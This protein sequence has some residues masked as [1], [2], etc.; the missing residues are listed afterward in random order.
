M[1]CDTDC[2]AELAR[3]QTC[4]S[5]CPVLENWI[6]MKEHISKHTMAFG[7]KM[8]LS[9]NIDSLPSELKDLSPQ[10]AFLIH[11]LIFNLVLYDK[12]TFLW[13]TW[14]PMISFP[15]KLLLSQ[16]CV[17]PVVKLF[18]IILQGFYCIHGSN[19]KK[20]LYRIKCPIFSDTPV[21]E[22]QPKTFVLAKVPCSPDCQVSAVCEILACQV[23]GLRLYCCYYL[24]VK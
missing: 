7:A 6:E 1:Y 11:F 18:H 12:V 23:S 19:R 10:A 9:W 16:M 21:A 24:W 3:R 17:I 4:Q 5:S 2:E 8:T 15:M 14:L 13:T 20:A 22:W